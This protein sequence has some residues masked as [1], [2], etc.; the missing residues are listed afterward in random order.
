MKKIL[1]ITFAILALILASCAPAVDPTPTPEEVTLTPEEPTPTPEEPTPTPEEPTPTPEEPTPTPTPDLA[2]VDPAEVLGP[3]DWVDDMATAANWVELP[4]EFTEIEFQD[5]QLQLTALGL[6]GWR[7]AHPTLGDF[8]LEYTIQSP[9]CTG[10]DNFGMVF[11]SPV[12]AEAEQV[13]L[14]GI[15]CDGHYSLRRWDE[16]E[17]N[18]IIP[19]TASDAIEPGASTENTIGLMAIGPQL[20][21]YINGEL[22]N[23]AFDDTWLFGH[24][25]VFV[26]SEEVFNVEMWVDQVRYWEDP[27]IT[28]VAP[29][30]TPVPITDDD[31]VA[32]LGPVDWVDNMA[33]GANWATGF[34]SFTNIRF[35]SGYLKL[36][37]TSDL[38]G[39]R[40]SWPVLDDFY[41]ES[42]V[43][44][45]NCS[46][47][48]EFGMVFRAPESIGA[49]KVYLF[50]IT[51][52]G[53][54][55]LR[56][57]DGHN[58]HVIIN[59]TQ[60]SNIQTGAS[61]T[62]RLGVMA[63]GSNLGLYINGHHVN[64]AVDGAYLSGQFGVFVGSHE[65]DNVEVWMEQIRYWENP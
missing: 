60:D 54:Y 56:R 20:S 43:L 53:R 58:M 39:W 25:G 24:F 21:L 28:P 63:Q 1:I 13:Y 33:T 48:D 61:N 51:C 65:V 30:P 22:V 45:P 55:S 41:L 3:P 6:L 31:P 2:E 16:D 10:S 4:N 64:E 50:G 12:S 40:L 36:T 11:R 17:M 15:T 26:D 35:D 9:N 19:L 18:I 37:S 42:T 38:I 29:T 14:Y 32:E 62:N 44:S 59:W 23:E 47:W 7:L 49:E 8:Y 46:G 57:W 34:S 52:N 5:G 27:E